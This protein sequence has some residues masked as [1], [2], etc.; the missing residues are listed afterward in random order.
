MLL[1]P[2]PPQQDG[3]AGRLLFCLCQ[4]YK[5]GAPSTT[6]CKLTADPERQSAGRPKWVEL[7]QLH[8]EPPAAAT[9]CLP[10]ADVAD[11]VDVRLAEHHAYERRVCGSRTI[12]ATRPVAVVRCEATW[13]RTPLRISKAPSTIFDD[14]YRAGGVGRVAGPDQTF[15]FM[16]PPRSGGSSDT[17]THGDCRRHERVGFGLSW[18]RGVQ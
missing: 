3:R 10:D 15:A 17:M 18:N 14:C 11:L 5:S 16:P 1:A 9:W 6:L 7:R 12:G 13:L 2:M 8:L 4:P